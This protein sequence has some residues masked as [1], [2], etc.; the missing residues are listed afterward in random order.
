[1]VKPDPQ[2]YK[3]VLDTLK[4]SPSEVCGHCLSMEK[5]VLEW[6]QSRKIEGPSLEGPVVKNLPSN[7][8]DTGSVPGWGTDI[9]HDVG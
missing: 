8:G 9:P 7:V 6:L 3:F 4:T 2:I 5:N 1:M